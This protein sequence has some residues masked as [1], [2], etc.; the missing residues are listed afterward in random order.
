MAEAGY[1]GTPLA[2]KLGIKDNYRCYFLHIPD[3]CFNLFDGLPSIHMVEK[4]ISESIDFAH[5][6]LMSQ[7][8]IKAFVP[9]VKSY[10]KKDATV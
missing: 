6:F 8:E 4:P 5:I 3:Y 1:S 2:K 9:E 10:L 7:E